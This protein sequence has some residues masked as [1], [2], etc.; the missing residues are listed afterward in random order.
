VY[1]AVNGMHNKLAPILNCLII[2]EKVENLQIHTFLYHFPNSSPLDS[3]LS[4]INAV[5][6]HQIFLTFLWTGIFQRARSMQV[7]WPRL[8]MHYPPFSFI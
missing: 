4:L 2:Y 8:R 7:F 1:T 5:H 6:G 3:L